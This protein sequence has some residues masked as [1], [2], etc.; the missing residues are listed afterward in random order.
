MLTKAVCLRCYLHSISL[1]DDRKGNKD[2]LKAGDIKRFE[3]R[4]KSQWVL[5]YNVR[6][7]R[8]EDCNESSEIHDTVPPWCRYT[9]EHV[10]NGGRLNK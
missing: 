7:D 5:C 10:V 4:W 6:P 2:A 1:N 9:L 8:K 3:H